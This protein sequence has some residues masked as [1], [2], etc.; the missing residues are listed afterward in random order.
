MEWEQIALNGA[1]ILSLFLLAYWFL[2]SIHKKFQFM[3]KRFDDITDDL[4][5][6]LIHF[7][8]RCNL[9]EKE[10]KD[11]NSSISGIGVRVTILET[12]MEER[13]HRASISQIPTIAKRPYRRRLKGE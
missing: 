3:E 5:V 11:I 13:S 7:N 9:M 8:K 2:H 1:L 6:I 4:Q 12:R 10:L